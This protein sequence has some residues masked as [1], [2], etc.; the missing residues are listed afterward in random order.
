[1][2]YSDFFVHMRISLTSKML[3]TRKSTPTT[4]KSINLNNLAYRANDISA[5]KF[6]I[7]TYFTIILTKFVPI[8]FFKV[9]KKLALANFEK[10][11]NTKSNHCQVNTNTG[12]HEPGPVHGS[13][14]NRKN[15]KIF[16]VV[17]RSL[18]KYSKK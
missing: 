18:R 13:E 17:R 14:Q 9:E 6:L 5:Y 11:K 12:I 2:F 4:F 3:E 10:P 7:V 8:T 15:G 16:R 1:M